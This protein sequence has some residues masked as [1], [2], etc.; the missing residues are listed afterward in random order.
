MPWASSQLAKACKSAHRWPSWAAEQRSRSQGLGGGA[1]GRVTRGTWDSLRHSGT[2]RGPDPVGAVYGGEQD[3]V[4]L[5]WP[6][7]S[8]K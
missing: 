8:R 5:D 1:A 6:R 7:S 2:F 4:K 3:G